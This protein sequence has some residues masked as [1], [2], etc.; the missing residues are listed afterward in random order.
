MSLLSRKDSSTCPSAQKPHKRGKMAVDRPGVH[1]MSGPPTTHRRRFET[2]ARDVLVENTCARTWRFASR[3]GQWCIQAQT[4]CLESLRVQGAITVLQPGPCFGGECVRRL[5]RAIKS[6]APLGQCWTSN[7]GP[8]R[9]KLVGL[10]VGDSGIQTT[11]GR[12]GLGGTTKS[13]APLGQCWT[14]D[15]GPSGARLVGPPAG[16]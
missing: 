5:E 1:G 4:L 3:S 14:S 15:Q 12:L 2:L 6:R 13:R 16:G 10:L 8:S 7:Q 11:G 9:A